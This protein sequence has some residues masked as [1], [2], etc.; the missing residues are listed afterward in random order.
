MKVTTDTDQDCIYD[1]L[2]KFDPQLEPLLKEDPNRFVIFPINYPG[3][4]YI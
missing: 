2:E 4:Y 1:D 3:N